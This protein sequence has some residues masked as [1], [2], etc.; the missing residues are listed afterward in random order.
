MANGNR[1]RA[2][3]T[4]I[5]EDNTI[6][7]QCGANIRFDSEH[8]EEYCT[9]CGLIT[10]ASIPYSSLQKVYYPYGLLL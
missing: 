10:R 6:C 5:D 9:E 3:L 2:R 4:R 7:P 1:R 8:M